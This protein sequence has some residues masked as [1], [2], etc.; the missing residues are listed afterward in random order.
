MRNGH[1]PSSMSWITY[2]FQL[3]PGVR[4]GIGTMPKNLKE[5]DEVFNKMDYRMLNILGIA[6]TVNR[7]PTHSLNIWWI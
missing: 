7:M 4:Y 6:S 3:W 1:L 2:K 5:A